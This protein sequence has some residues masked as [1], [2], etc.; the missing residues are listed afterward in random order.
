MKVCAACDRAQSFTGC[1]AGTDRVGGDAEEGGHQR[2]LQ[3]A[4]DQPVEQGGAE[5]DIV[6]HRLD[7][8]LRLITQQEL[9]D[10]NIGSIETGRLR[11]ALEPPRHHVGP[12]LPRGRALVPQRLAEFAQLVRR[13]PVVGVDVRPLQA[14]KEAPARDLRVVIGVDQPI[15]QRR[16]RLVPVM[17][18]L[19]GIGEIGEDEM[20]LVC[21]RHGSLHFRVVKRS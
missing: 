4:V 8:R 7:D 17:K 21:A 10:G 12:R 3:A 13:Y 5:E 9:Q 14:A 15:G 16:R 11:E 2:A 1:K 6:D 19:G 20:S 18:P